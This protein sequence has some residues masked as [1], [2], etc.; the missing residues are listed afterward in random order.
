M[1]RLSSEQSA[2]ARPSRACADDDEAKPPARA[3]KRRRSPSAT[4]AAVAA[5]ATL[6]VAASSASAHVNSDDNGAKRRRTLV[7]AGATAAGGARDAVSGERSDDSDDDADAD[8]DAD[9]DGAPSAPMSREEQQRAHEAYARQL[10]VAG[11]ARVCDAHSKHSRT[12]NLLR[13]PAAGGGASARLRRSRRASVPLRLDFSRSPPRAVLTSLALPPAPSS[14]L[15]LS[16]PVCRSATHAALH[17][18]SASRRRTNAACAASGCGSCRRPRPQHHRSSPRF[19][20]RVTS[21]I[22]AQPPFR[23][24]PYLC[25]AAASHCLVKIFY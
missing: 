18:R 7:R 5:A 15:S 25:Q 8:A 13:A 19:T 12:K 6:R 23:R 14:L 16:P 11:P 3:S 21:R 17:C 2:A 22:A 9:A 4:A 1:A 20:P 10:Q 24:R